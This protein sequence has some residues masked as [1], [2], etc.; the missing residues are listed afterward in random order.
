MCSHV[1]HPVGKELR[2]PGPEIY[3]GCSN[4]QLLRFGLQAGSANQVSP[5]EWRLPALIRRISREKRTPSLAPRGCP[6]P[7]P[8]KKSF[9]F[10]ALRA[11]WCYLV[12][13][14]ELFGFFASLSV[15][16]NPDNQLHF[17]TLPEL[18]ILPIPPIRNVQAITVDQ[19]AL[20]RPPL[21]APINTVEAVDFCVIKKTGLGLFSLREKLVP[22]KVINIQFQ[23]CGI[24]TGSDRISPWPIAGRA[25]VGLGP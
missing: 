17:F 19:R 5:M 4:G 15:F 20:T 12:C 10:H 22:H 16:L 9:S 8:S 3:V 7:N 6:P 14:A 21:D 24:F 18:N 1:H 11:F 23:Q 13:L 2:S 25:R